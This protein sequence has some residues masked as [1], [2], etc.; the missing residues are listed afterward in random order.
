ME[1]NMEKLDSRISQ[2]ED[3]RKEQELDLQGFKEIRI[4][5][6][7]DKGKEKI[8]A[9]VTHQAK[10][11]KPFNIQFKPEQP[12][13]KRT[14]FIYQLPKPQ[15][16]TYSEITKKPTQSQFVHRVHSYLTQFI[17]VA[18]YL[19]KNIQSPD[20][21]PERL[22]G[23][24]TKPLKGYNKLIALNNTDPKL[25]QTM[26]NYG[27]LHAVYTQ[28]GDNLQH[29]PELHQVVKKYLGI[30]KAE[31][32]FIRIYSAPCEVTPQEIYH[33]ITAVKIGLTR[34]IICEDPTVQPDLTIQ[35]IV[36][37]LQHKRAIMIKVI[38][39]ELIN[40]YEEG[41]KWI[42]NSKNSTII[43]SNAKITKDIE[44]LPK[45][46]TTLANWETTPTTNAL[47]TYPKYMTEKTKYLLCQQLKELFNLH[48]CSYCNQ[49][50]LLPNVYLPTIIT[51][52]DKE[53]KE[54][55]G[56]NSTT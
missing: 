4:S 29:I 5:H 46:I 8:D 24:Q 44:E 40:S 50:D 42:Y 20:Y 27:L 21:N 54:E 47:R 14:D 32:I 49:K 52:E 48:H 34:S 30:T 51:Q 6:E 56:S 19:N 43:Y 39:Q 1:K 9:V 41:G 37:F 38:I 26:Y 7:N 53:D 17:Q 55:E 2:M 22:I 25:V 13:P 10:K 11:Y 16:N 28:N 45:W 23:W 36:E 33:P 15:I 12:I 31:L 3:S 18:N 35:E